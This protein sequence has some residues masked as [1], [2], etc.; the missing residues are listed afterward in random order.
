MPDIE[1]GTKEFQPVQNLPSLHI[2]TE[3][4][5]IVSFSAIIAL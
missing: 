5:I 4:C 2:N 1:L 3:H